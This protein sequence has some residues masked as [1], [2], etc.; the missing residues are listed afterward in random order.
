MEHF[1]ALNDSVESVCNG[2]DRC[3]SKLLTD[4]LL[5][6]L[7]GH[8]IDVCGGLVK[9]DDFVV[10]E[11]GAD[12]A[13]ELALSD[14]EVLALFLDLELETLSFFILLFLILILFFLFSL[15]R[16]GLVAIFLFIL[17]FFAFC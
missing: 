17:R 12:D 11:D 15:F 4:Q 8:D 9:Q 13:D 5:D 14:T 3:A 1:I 6:R 2:Q 16:L 10:A 7:L